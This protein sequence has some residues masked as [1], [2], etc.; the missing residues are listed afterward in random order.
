MS[1]YTSPVRVLFFGGG[2]DTQVEHKTYYTWGCPVQV[3][4]LYANF[5]FLPNFKV[6]SRNTP[7]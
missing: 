4:S 5:L 1:Q 7:E 2:G 6:M 3:Q